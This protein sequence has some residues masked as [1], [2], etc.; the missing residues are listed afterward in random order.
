MR[1]T[2]DPRANTTGILT[3]RVPDRLHRFEPPSFSTYTVSML[4][5]E[6]HLFLDNAAGLT[7]LDQ[8]QLLFFRSAPACIWDLLPAP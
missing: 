1:L 2:D 5:G 4:G 6:S 7:W 8:H 3:G